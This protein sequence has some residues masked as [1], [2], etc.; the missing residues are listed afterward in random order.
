MKNIGKPCAL[1]HARFDEGGGVKP[2][3]YSTIGFTVAALSVD[4]TVLPG[5][6]MYTFANITGN[7]YISR[8]KQQ[9]GAL[10]G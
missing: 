5:V 4:G 7:H 1:T 2:A 6:A 8:I 3:P 10:H 9:Y